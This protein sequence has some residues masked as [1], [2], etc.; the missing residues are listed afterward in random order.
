MTILNFGLLL[1]VVQVIISASIR[2]TVFLE[3][4]A[5]SRKGGSEGG[6]MA[7]ESRHFPYPGEREKGG[8][9]LRVG[10]HASCV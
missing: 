5:N 8:G 10:L 4:P 6:K 3:Y 2:K 9:G 1:S 7:I